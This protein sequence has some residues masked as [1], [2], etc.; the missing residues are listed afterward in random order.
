[1]LIICLSFAYHVANSKRHADSHYKSLLVKILLLC[2]GRLAIVIVI[3]IQ[4]QENAIIV[5]NKKIKF[6]YIS[7][8]SD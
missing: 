5:S 1:M 7:S 3:V 8:Y 2:Q 6:E 4:I